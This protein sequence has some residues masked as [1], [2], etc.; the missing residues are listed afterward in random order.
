MVIQTG[1]GDHEL[2]IKQNG[3]KIEFNLK[4][5][6]ADDIIEMTIVEYNKLCELLE[7]FKKT[8]K[9]KLPEKQKRKKK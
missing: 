7:I 9:V 2:I 8:I 3:E 1:L 4:S 5:D 6:D